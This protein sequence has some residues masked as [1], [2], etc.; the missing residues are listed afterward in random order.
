MKIKESSR[1]K[2]IKIKKINNE[3]YKTKTFFFDY[4]IDINP[5]QFIMLWIPGIDEKPFAVSY[6]QPMA[7]TAE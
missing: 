4:D 6:K 1:Y 5:G 3:N 2:K 7:I